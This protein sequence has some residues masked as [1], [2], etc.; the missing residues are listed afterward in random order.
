M[1][2][3]KIFLFLLSTVVF[4]MTSCLKERAMNIDPSKGTPNVI[5]FA[6]TGDN[7][8]G[9][10][11]KYPRFTSDLGSV[12]A[13]ETKKFN[14]NVSYSGAEAAPQDITV[15]LA[16]DPELLTQFN[17]ENG[18]N[19]VV[20]PTEIYT[21]PTTVV[22][23]QGQHQATVEVA[24][25]NNSSYDFNVNYALPLKI[26]SAT[27]GTISS[28]FGKAV[29]SFSARNSYDGVYTMSA[30][31]PMVDLLSSSLS[32]WY[33]IDMQLITYTGNSV[34][35]YD[36]INYV[37]AYGHPI[38]SGSSGSYYGT[39]SPVFFFDATGKITS[40]T[41]YYGQNAGGNKRSAELD[42]TG[43][44]Q[45]TFNAD[46]SIKSFEVSYIMTQS[47]S[48]PNAPRTYFHEKFTYVGPR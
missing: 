36:G 13:G 42:P 26:V 5:E 43:V 34:A 11:S 6:N 47:V 9:S 12:G 18:T 32:G 3:S 45:A 33:P 10:L 41:N 38:K 44:N 21:V 2:Q 28:N 17:T 29:Y 37:D 19:Y 30:T 8:A 35:L 20:P 7:V 16:V 39:F 25:T 22:I 14:V 40:V 31:A 27:K 46:G 23:K 4:S 15:T 1:K 48:T 24:V